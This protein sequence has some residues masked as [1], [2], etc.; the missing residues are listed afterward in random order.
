M[1]RDAVNFAHEGA[2]SQELL[3]KYIIYARKHIHPKFPNENIEKVTSFYAELRRESQTVGG[4]T[5]VTRHIESLIRM[6]QASARIHLRQEVKKEDVDL[7]I[8][9]LCTIGLY[10]WR[11]SS[12][13]RRSASGKPLGKGSRATYLSRKTRT[14]CC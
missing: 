7:A 12:S 11:A 3:K 5:I 6:A 2:V 4:I 13:L 1:L 10:Q 8:S 14:P 9:V